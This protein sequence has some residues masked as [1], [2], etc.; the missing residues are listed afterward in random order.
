MKISTKFFSS[1]LGLGALIIA[2]VSG[3]NIWI[4]LQEL[5]I[6]T[7]ESA[8]R[9]RQE[10]YTQLR[11]LLDEQI[12][13]LK[14]FLVLNRDPEEIE[15][16]QKAKSGFVLTLEE[17]RAEYPEKEALI[18][19][20]QRYQN[21][22]A[23]AD[24]LGDTV[25]NDS[26]L[27]QDIR[28][29]NFFRRD[30]ELYLNE[31]E[32][33]VESQ[34][35]AAIAEK[36]DLNQLFARIIWVVVL[37]I[38]ALMVLQYQA[39]VSPVLASLDRLSKGAKHLS[40]GDFEY[41]LNIQGS[42][43]LAHVAQTFD[44]MTAALA[45]AYE[46]LEFKVNQRTAQIEQKNAVLKDEILKRE[47]I[48]E[49]LRRIFEDTKQSQQLLSSIINATPDWIFVKDTNFRFVLVNDSFAS[50]F[51]LNHEDI[52]GRT[53]SEILTTQD[54]GEGITSK[55]EKIIRQEDE[56]ILLGKTVHNPSDHVTDVHGIEY[57]LDT[58]K[59]P[60]LD[61]EKN[62]VGILGVSRDITDRHL[63]IEAL[64][65]SEGELR[66]KADEL[67]KTLQQLRQT[68]TQI[69]QSE[70]MSSLGQ[71]VAGVAHEINNPVNFIFGNINHARDYISDLLGLIEL[72]RT[73]YPEPSQTIQ[74]EIEVIELDYVIEDMPKLLSSMMVGAE[75]IREIVKSLRV[76]SRL[77][78]SEM[79]QVDIHA[80]IDSTLMILQNRLKKS[81]ERGAIAIERQYGELP[82]VECY[83]GQL[84]QVFMNILS[85]G[86]DAL[87]DYNA[88][89]SPAEKQAKPSRITIKTEK[90]APTPDLSGRIRI[91]IIDNGPGIPEKVRQ[92]LFEPF[93]TTKEVGKGTGLGLSIS[94]SIIVEKHGG[95][96]T[97]FSE[98]DQ[99]TEFI[100]EIPI[101]A[102]KMM[103][104]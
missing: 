22:R 20:E 95:E 60:L 48:E 100:I 25:E 33:E 38:V 16:Y 53:I 14:D 78:E 19:L 88:R 65:Q 58:Q 90:Q 67:E 3:A 36:K 82:L 89:R 77:D 29:I 41:R 104:S 91:R 69:V 5:R 50:H 59:I 83:A 101:K 28:S 68:Q 70:K 55:D 84:N 12:I 86:I 9:A 103:A 11:L 63:A 73:E 79:K 94:H 42:D 76:F 45:T 49:E 75:R 51:Q 30:I 61:E 54:L 93:F 66:Q 34:I 31:L 26:I 21:I 27:Q 39:I 37:F 64:E 74:A 4:Q 40:N 23:I 24:R 6:E 8:V 97:C 32:Q 10:Q 43:E 81:Q 102:K 7:R 99:G 85:N 1:S 98:E 46:D 35:L 13:G 80:G 15:R 52:I 62:V 44:R 57:V 18:F 47:V 96:L 56:E 71:M 92:R 72:Y 17:L 87:D 2:L